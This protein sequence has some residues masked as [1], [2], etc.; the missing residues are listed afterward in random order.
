MDESLKCSAFQEQDREIVNILIDSDL[1]FDMDLPERLKL[2][3][4]IERF[5]FGSTAE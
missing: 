5:F 4:H 2:L 1:Y 3:H